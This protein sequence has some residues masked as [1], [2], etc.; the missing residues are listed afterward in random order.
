MNKYVN[1]EY[2]LFRLSKGGL[3]SFCIIFVPLYAVSYDS[4]GKVDNV[5]AN[6]RR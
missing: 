4:K 6:K 1:S 3:F 5:L 2:Y